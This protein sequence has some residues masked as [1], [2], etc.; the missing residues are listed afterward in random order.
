MRCHGGSRP[1]ETSVCMAEALLD[2]LKRYV[3][4]GP[5]DEE[6][7]RSLHARAAPR[8]AGIADAFYARILQHEEAR[9]ALSGGESRVGHLKVTLQRWMG[10]VLL[11]PW[12]EAWF[13][14]HCRIGRVHVRI[15]LPQHYM[16][17]AMNLV[18]DELGRVA[19][20]A[21]ADDPP[22]LAGVRR[23]LDKVLDLE[24]A[25]MLHTYREDLLAR[26][27][28]SERLAAFGQVVGSIGHDLR[29][30]LGVI[31][32]SLYLMR[33]RVR[34]DPGVLKHI[35]R[36]GEQVTIANGIITDLLEM[37]R[38]R[39][40]RREPVA[41][42]RLVEEAAASVPRPRGVSVE[43]AGFEGLPEVVGDA[44]LLRQLAVNLASNA[45]E[46]AAPQG[47]VLIR[48]GMEG[49]EA[50]IT[51]EDSGPGVD[52]S[53][54]GQMFEPLVTTKLGGIGLGLAL[55]KRIA[56]R[57]GGTVVHEPRP[58]RGARFVVRLPAGDPH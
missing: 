36:I 33:V 21:W 8:L 57:H 29:N 53:V 23:A 15:D 20:E 42:G 35:D 17:G 38:E 22:R 11:G 37:V 9:R 25:I 51:V 24:L 1:I 5:P 14:A 28:R 43:I 26:A 18:R 13:E 32:S 58:G 7:L 56:E 41:L 30:P 50:C 39:P 49:G 10:E 55:V 31:E 45:V 40:L 16:F 12:D 2:E 44:G 46:A 4:F 54:R 47:Q 27:R 34:D 19:D 52:P 3:T 6:A 48:G